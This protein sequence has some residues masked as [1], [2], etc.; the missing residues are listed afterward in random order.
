M[1]KSFVLARLFGIP[2]KLHWSYYFVLIYAVLQLISEPAHGIILLVVLA[3]LS[4]S[5]VAHELAHTLV[6]RKFKIQT[7]DILLTPIGGM[8]RMTNL[9]T[10]PR[11]E[12]LVASA[13]PALSILIGLLTLP[14]LIMT[15][16]QTS[17]VSSILGVFYQTMVGILSL[18]SFLN[19][20]LGVFNL[21]PAF[22]MDGGRILRAIL[23]RKLGIVRATEIAASIGKFLALIGFVAGIT[24]SYFSLVII[25]IF[26]FITSSIE[27]SMVRRREMMKQMQMGGASPFNQQFQVDLMNLFRVFSSQMQQRQTP[28]EPPTQDYPETQNTRAEND[29]GYFE[30][31]GQQ[32]FMPEKPDEND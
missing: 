1:F 14:F 11:Q 12:I 2:I 6:A 22:P 28:P 26:I 7:F 25:A 23:N 15:L 9:P 5:V 20:V 32:V 24:M 18:V 29:S 21:I 4:I 19:L 3:I 13:G 30:Y 17:D 8:A 10:E 27:L 31:K 16:N